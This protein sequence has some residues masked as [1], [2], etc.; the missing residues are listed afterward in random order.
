ATVRHR[1]RAHARGGVCG[2]VCREIEG[3]EREARRVHKTAV[4]VAEQAA[5]IW[6]N[7]KDAVASPFFGQTLFNNIPQDFIDYH[8][9]IP[10]YDRLFRNLNFIE[11]DD[12]RSIFGPAAYFVDL[13]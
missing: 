12:C 3:G 9:S 4:N 2:E 5:L 10:D 11:C 6:A 13:M 8:Q 1:N 7:I